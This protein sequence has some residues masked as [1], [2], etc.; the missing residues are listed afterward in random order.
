MAACKKN[1][2][3]ESEV[4]AASSKSSVVN[5]FVTREHGYL[6]TTVG[7]KHVMSMAS[8]IG[9]KR[10]FVD[11]WSRGC[12]LFKS[13]VMKAYGGP[14]ICAE[15]E[16]DPL[17]ELMQYGK[18]LNVEVVPWFEWGNI[19]PA[20]SVLWNRNKSRGWV[21]F[22]ESFH[23]VPSIRINPYKGDFD[24]FYA[25]LMKE[26]VTKYG[27]KE[28]HIC[29]NFAPHTK[30][31]PATA[32]KGP[33][34]FTAFAKKALQPARAAGA[35]VSLSSQ[36]RMNSLQTFSIDWHSW[37]NSGVV[38]WVYPQLYHVGESK[39][40]QFV[41]EAKAERG[42]GAVGVAL[43]SG[44]STERWTLDGLGRL[45]K[46]ARSMG[47]ESAI[48]DFNS[49]LSDLKASKN[50]DVEKI[51][52]AFGTR[53]RAQATGNSSTKPQSTPA[54]QT[55]PP[56]PQL[57]PP[58]NP[59]PAA[60]ATTTATTTPASPGSESSTPTDSA[61]SPNGSPVV[62]TRLCE[63][64]KISGAPVEGAPTYLST[65]NSDPVDASP[66]D[67]LAYRHLTQV[68]INGELMMYVTLYSSDGSSRVR[69]VQARYLVERRPD[70]LTC[71][72]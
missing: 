20:K 4:E 58:E 34:A 30:Y 33:V 8:R 51:A 41:S 67:Q 2:T 56:A 14:E 22:E 24:D 3:T 25:A 15:S 64:M 18:S 36:R 37:L 11:V 48:F 61:S 49:L 1:S 68:N 12:T 27:A 39:T 54:Q 46:L 59:V 16:G 72:P 31:G 32:I 52:S 26:V 45:V 13:N 50:A 60:T 19:V 62:K 44:P 40:D 5:G 53:A 6:D 55:P 29:D 35:R 7:R 28:I 65:V 57:P 10:V 17:A 69:W 23:T 9:L 21:G 70:E 66:N 42:Y 47:L 38:D 63:Y 71:A 43:Y